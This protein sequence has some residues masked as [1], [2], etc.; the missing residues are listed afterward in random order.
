[1][2]KSWFQKVA[3]RE[4]E[5]LREIAVGQSRR[6]AKDTFATAV[7]PD[8]GQQGA[9]TILPKGT[10]VGAVEGE[11]FLASQNGMQWYSYR[12]V[13]PLSLEEGP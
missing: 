13:E 8:T 11:L 3:E 4:S 12:T 5:I 1:M 2:S 9:M 7:Y 6:L 10:F